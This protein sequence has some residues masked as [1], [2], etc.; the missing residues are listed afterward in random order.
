MAEVPSSMTVF[1]GLM[2]AVFPGADP[3]PVPGPSPSARK[4]A[5]YIPGLAPLYFYVTHSALATCG[6]RR[7]PRSAALEREASTGSTWSWRTAPRSCGT[8]RSPTQASTFAASSPVFDYAVVDATTAGAAGRPLVLV[9]GTV[10]SFEW[11]D[12]APASS[13]WRVRKTPRECCVDTSARTMCGWA[14]LP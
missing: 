9:A 12:G 13:N 11:C 5:L 1:P 4:N 6:G 3:R 2:P 14:T 10:S 7:W 8:E